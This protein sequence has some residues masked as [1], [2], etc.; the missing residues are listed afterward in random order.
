MHF[1]SGNFI[2]HSTMVVEELGS[3]QDRGPEDGLGLGDHLRGRET[4]EEEAA[5]R[6]LVHQPEESQLL[7]LPILLL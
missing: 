3:R 1:F 4:S 7:G 2:L 6:L 5:P